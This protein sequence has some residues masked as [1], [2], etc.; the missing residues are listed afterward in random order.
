MTWTRYKQGKLFKTQINDPTVQVDVI[1][2]NAL[3]VA[4]ITGHID[5]YCVKVNFFQIFRNNVNVVNAFVGPLSFDATMFQS[6]RH[7][8]T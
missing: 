5:W 4:E 2:I 6:D 7:L 8:R 1:Q 3:Q